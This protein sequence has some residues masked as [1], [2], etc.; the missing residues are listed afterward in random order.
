MVEELSPGSIHFK[1][2]QA[3][4]TPLQLAMIYGSVREGRFCDTVAR[5]AASEIERSA[6]FELDVID[7]CPEWPHLDEQRFQQRIMAADAIIVV[8][9]EYNHSFPGPLKT[10]IDS[11]S[12]EWRAKPVA[13]VSYGGVS[14]GLRA[15]EH[16]LGVFAELDAV[17]IRESVS[18]RNAW[19]RFTDEGRPIEEERCQRSI[20]TLLSQLTWWARTLKAGRQAE[21]YGAAA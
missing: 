11:A 9:P 4:K 8:T 5:W 2:E 3:M 20:R 7:P 21:A 18:F 12:S 15:V 14:G 13:F 17:A 19:E 16:L 1:E 6:D 10:L